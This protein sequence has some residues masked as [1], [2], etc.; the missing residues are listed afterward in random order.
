MATLTDDTTNAGLTG[1]AGEVEV[2]EI[3]GE[4]LDK[5]NEF[6]APLQPGYHT[7]TFDGLDEKKPIQTRERGGKQVAE[8]TFTATSVPTDPTTKPR[9]LHYQRLDTYLSDAQKAKGMTSGVGKL[10]H[11][12]GLTDTFNRTGRKVADIVAVLQQAEGERGT[13]RAKVEWESYDKDTKTTTSSNPRTYTNGKGEVVVIQ[14]WPRTST[15]ALSED[16]TNFPEKIVDVK[17]VKK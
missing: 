4:V 13:F 15:G 2:E 17:P 5:Q 10:I 9:T 7:F 8:I 6:A 11:A 12:L 16:L 1:I 3:N 14:G